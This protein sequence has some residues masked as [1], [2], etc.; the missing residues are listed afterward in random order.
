V[1]GV[2]FDDHNKWK[3]EQ[4]YDFFGFTCDDLRAIA[5]KIDELQA[6]SFDDLNR[7]FKR[8]EYAETN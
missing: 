2:I 5:D 1:L 7:L 6:M 4:R 3:Y 8:F